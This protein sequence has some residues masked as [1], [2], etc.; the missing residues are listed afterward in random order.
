[1]DRSGRSGRESGSPSP[2]SSLMSEL[3]RWVT[4][5]CRGPGGGPSV[6]ELRDILLEPPSLL[7]R[8]MA[9]GVILGPVMALA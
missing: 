3:V 7:D 9:R 8:D 6:S 2:S 4:D 5:G 1:M